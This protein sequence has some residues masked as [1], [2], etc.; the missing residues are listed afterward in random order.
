MRRPTD[1]RPRVLLKDCPLPGG[2]KGRLHLESQ[3]RTSRPPG[4]PCKAVS[5]AGAFRPR[6]VAR[7]CKRS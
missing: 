1:V 6:Q 7:L 5:L 4:C 2:E 3:G